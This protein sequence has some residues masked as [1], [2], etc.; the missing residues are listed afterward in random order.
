MTNNDLIEAI[1]I[2]AR[3]T[4][5]IG[6]RHIAEYEASTGSRMPYRK[7]VVEHWIRQARDDLMRNGTEQNVDLANEAARHIRPGSLE[8]GTLH[9]DVDL[10]AQGPLDAITI[11]VSYSEEDG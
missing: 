7:G 3:R 2:T 9:L 6:E 10:P 8:G 4:R 1:I 5:E 11:A